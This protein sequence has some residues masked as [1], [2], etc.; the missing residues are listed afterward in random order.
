MQLEVWN[1]KVKMVRQFDSGFTVL[2]LE[3]DNEGSEL[4]LFFDNAEE[5]DEFGVSVSTAALAPVVS[6]PKEDGA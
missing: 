6:P 3:A 4:N 5:V 1:V 2:K